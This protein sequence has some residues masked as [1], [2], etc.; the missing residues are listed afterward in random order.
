MNK[1]TYRP[2]MIKINIKIYG[3][4]MVKYTDWIEIFKYIRGSRDR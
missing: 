4:V 2:E 1:Y 3:A